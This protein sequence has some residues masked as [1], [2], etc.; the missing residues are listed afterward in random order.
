MS[1]SDIEQASFDETS[2]GGWDAAQVKVFLLDV[3]KSV[4]KLERRVEEAH[5]M[6]TAAMELVTQAEALVDQVKDQ[7]DGN[8]DTGEAAEAA[9]RLIA[10]A[11]ARAQEIERAAA[12]RVRAAEN[13]VTASLDR[14]KGE[15]AMAVR[16][17]E[18]NAAQLI[19]DAEARAHEIESAAA[20]RVLAAEDEVAAVLERSKGEAASIVRESERIAA[21]LI[22]EAQSE[23]GW[24]RIEAAANAEHEREAVRH[25]AAKVRELA[26]VDAAA[27]VAGALEEADRVTQRVFRNVATVPGRAEVERIVAEAEAL[28]ENARAES[29]AIVAQAMDQV[30]TSGEG[31]ELSDEVRRSVSALRTVTN[32]RTREA[33]EGPVQQV[34]GRALQMLA[35]VR[36][37]DGQMSPD[38]RAALA[39]EL[40]GLQD[41]IAKLEEGLLNNNNDGAPTMRVVL[42]LTGEDADDSGEALARRPSRYQQRSANLPKIGSRVESV[43]RAMQSMR[44]SMKEP[45]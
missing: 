41:L 1:S 28:L 10:E 19:A 6:R 7:A 13:Q 8:G 4:R 23:L 36:R 26:R 30:G 22:E 27:I 16:K 18:R 20:D 33:E 14:G 21:Q 2:D 39:E 5:E 29:E 3:A 35:Q 40:H 25:D 17:A 12:A 43:N 11:E 32:A 24:R 42:D 9:E 38:E 37:G 31:D 45:E 34:R 44:D 15:A